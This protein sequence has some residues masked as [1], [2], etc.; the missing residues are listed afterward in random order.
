MAR[1]AANRNKR[2][3]PAPQKQPQQ[4][5]AVKHSGG[6][7]IESTLFFVRLRKN[8]RW[9]FIFLALVFAGGF[10]FFGVGS[11]STGVSDL[12]SGNAQ[13][14]KTLLL[15]IAG[16][17]AVASI[18]LL[19][20]KMVNIGIVCLVIAI[21]LGV[22]YA[23]THKKG[24]A[25]ITSAQKAATAHPKDPAVWKALA[26]T[27]Q[28]AQPVQDLC[29]IDALEHY[30]KLKPRD[31]AVLSQLAALYEGS[32]RQEGNAAAIAQQEVQSLQGQNFGPVPTSKLGQALNSSNNPVQQAV[33][34]AANAEFQRLYSAYQ[35]TRRNQ[36][37]VYKKLVDLDAT[38][39]TSLLQYAQVAEQARDY[40]TAYAA[41]QLF[42]KRFPDDVVDAAR[43]K[44]QM[45]VLKPLLQLPT[46]TTSP[47]G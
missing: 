12:F 15:I 42:L 43:V 30:V 8:A 10:V 34:N 24:N 17:L 38:D 41:Y 3:K 9:V 1:A 14:G 36:E 40:K 33:L 13:F 26:T 46:S 2:P 16:V 39:V 6:A 19:I 27:C 7:G 31:G 4:Q 11:G 44:Q 37:A 35:Q 47:S 32:A 28:T 25:A 18:V 29:A 22:A 5:R 21:G 45:K 23:V 20:Y